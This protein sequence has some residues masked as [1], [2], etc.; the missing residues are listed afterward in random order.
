MLSDIQRM[1]GF[2][3]GTSSKETSDRVSNEQQ[4]G[5]FGVGMDTIPLP[6]K[7]RSTI[8]YW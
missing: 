3:S 7:C 4:R 1:D 8:H 6:S 2:H 5:K